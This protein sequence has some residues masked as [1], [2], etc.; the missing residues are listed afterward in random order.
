MENIL[1]SIVACLSRGLAFQ[2]NCFVCRSSLSLRQIGILRIKNP[3][4]EIIQFSRWDKN[5]LSHLNGPSGSWNESLFCPGYFELGGVHYLLP[6]GSTYSVGYPYSQYVG[7]VE[8]STPFFETPVSA[9][10]LIDGPREKNNLLPGLKGEIAL[11]TPC[12]VLVGDEVWVYYSAMDRADGIW[13]MVL[14]SFKIL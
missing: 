12:P 5:P 1:F 8:A 10:P 3:A 14:S 13:K 11:D 2:E 7:L 6:A 9:R 4:G